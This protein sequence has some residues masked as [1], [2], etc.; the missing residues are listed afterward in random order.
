VGL[1]KKLIDSIAGSPGKPIESGRPAARVSNSPR[2]RPE[3]FKNEGEAGLLCSPTSL[4][5]EK[6]PSTLFP[7]FPDSLPQNS[8][9]I[10]DEMIDGLDAAFD[11][12]CLLTPGNEAGHA[13]LQADEEASIRALFAD[14]TA[15]YAV[16]LKNF[17][18]DLHR[19][20]GTRDSIEFCR[21]VLRSLRS[22]AETINM[23]ET[24]RRMEE[25]DR[26]LALGQTGTNRFLVGE[27]RDQILSKYESLAEVLPASFRVGDENQKREDIIIRSLLQEIPG[28]GCVTLEKLYQSGLGSLQMLLMGNPEDLA[29][30]TAIRRPLCEKICLKMSQYRT[31]TES[32]ASQPGQSG[33][34]T[35][36]VEIA[37]ELG[38][39]IDG[40]G[41]RPG[42]HP[43]DDSGFE[44]R[45]CRKKRMELF[46]EVKVTLAEL[47]ELDLIRKLEKV[48]F[49]RRL[50]LLDEHLAHWKADI[51]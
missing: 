43:V 4:P 23:P 17:I 38:M 45:E 9:A 33:C 42:S 26:C 48:S 21:P 15:A 12:A 49:K 25:L 39:L 10:L 19:H 14:I 5:Q 51:I 28:V 16:P 30:A 32:R 20:T 37:N 47:G 50:N 27:I 40:K 1:F 46:L 24:V 34:R 31:E 13:G 3:T 29:A 11:N 35:R 22:A 44:R 36:L 8:D 2:Q 41:T 7:E 18:F 6:P